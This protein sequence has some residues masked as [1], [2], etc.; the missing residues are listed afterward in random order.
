MS[1]HP[2]P[3]V[4]ATPFTVPSEEWQR[5]VQAVHIRKARRVGWRLWSARSSGARTRN[6]RRGVSDAL[7]HSLCAAPDQEDLNAVVMNYLI[8]EGYAQ[9]AAQFQEESRTAG[10]HVDRPRL[11]FSHLTRACCLHPRQPGWTCPRWAHAW[12][13][14]SR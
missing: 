2:R 6:M 12:V 8:T 5:R 3:V 13:C 14:T 10:E 11:P 9:A 4:P 1:R 7:T